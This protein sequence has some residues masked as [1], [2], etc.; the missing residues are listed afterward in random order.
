MR[1]RWVARPAPGLNIKEASNPRNLP[2]SI[3]L[4]LTRRGLSGEKLDRFLHPD[5]NSLSCWQD[6]GGVRKAAERIV[7]GIQNNENIMVHGDFDADGITATTIVYMGLRSLGA[8]IDYF[9]PDRFEDG[10]GLGESSIEVCKADNTNLFIT[11][12]C[13]ITAAGYVENLKSMNVDTI[14]T[15]HHQP[16]SILPDAEAVV[17]PVLDGDTPYS[18]LAGA[19]VAWMVVRAVYDLLDADKEYLHELLQLVAIG[20]VTDVVE[21]I[22]DNRILVSEGL[23]LL[24]TR[25]LPGISA[26]AESSSVDIQ[27]MNSTDLAYYLGPRINACG[28]IGHAEDAV[29]LLLAGSSEEAGE[30]IKTVEEY[31]R[32]RRKLDSE[33]EEHIIQ[34]VEALDNPS[35]IVMADEGWHRGVIGIVA[36][37]LVS[38]YGVPS[39]II[40][41]EKGNGYGSARSVPGIPI[42]SIL[43]G[44]QAEHGIM[45]S[46]GGHPMAAGFRIPTGNISILREELI[47]ILSGTEWEARLGSVLYIDGKLEEQ[48]YNAKTLRAIEILEPFGEGNKKPVWLA[49]GAYPVQWR[50]VGKSAKHLS[51][52][53]RIGSAVHKA[54][55]FNMVNSQSLFNGKVDLA[56]TLALDTYRGD[57]SIQLILKGIRKHRKAAN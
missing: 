53:F 36:S 11:V 4:L 40:S 28:R 6:I 18:K 10:Y 49:R 47:S 5:M 15:D 30:L 55:G 20:T 24:R 38:R 32:I 29:K 7:H 33:I 46:L 48:D 26:L 27:Q 1:K 50:A 19:G 8:H 52:N 9:I 44:I 39:I 17:D 3:S 43:T 37:R 51:C 54:I 41:I 14:I 34:L 56:F 42:Y 23:K 45:D 16:G 21:L 2:Q 22:D 35:C 31:N 57:G 13:G 25:T 12:D